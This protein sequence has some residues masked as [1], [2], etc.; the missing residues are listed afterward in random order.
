MTRKTGRFSLTVAVRG[1]YYQPPS[2]RSPPSAL[3]PRAIPPDLRRNPAERPHWTP[4][5]TD[6]P[7][8]DACRLWGSVF[9][10]P[11]NPVARTEESPMGLLASLTSTAQPFIEQ[12]EI[13]ELLRVTSR[14][15]RTWIHLGRFP[16]P[17]PVGRRRQ[18]WSRADVMRALGQREKQIRERRDD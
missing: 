5:P 2:G 12:R 8:W 13:L 6:V 1:S 4:Q 9:S 7:T 18:F 14:T 3:S 10:T 17:L 11:Q 16:K 15:L